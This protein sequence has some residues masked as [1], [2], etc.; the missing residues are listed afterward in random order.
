MGAQV[1]FLGMM[2][3]ELWERGVAP[4]QWPIIFKKKQ[5]IGGQFFGKRQLKMSTSSLLL[6]EYPPCME[7]SELMSI[8]AVYGASSS[9]KSLN[10][11][12]LRSRKTLN[13]G[14]GRNKIPV[15]VFY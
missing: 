8:R 3:A 12:L 10:M 13:I 1:G 5:K 15:W 9:T 14:G 4:Q 11:F 2:E 6:T 7:T